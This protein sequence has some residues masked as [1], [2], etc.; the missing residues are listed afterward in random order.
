[1]ETEKL[2]TSCSSP[3]T[4]SKAIE[5][6]G[7]NA[8]IETPAAKHAIRNL[9]SVLKSHGA[10][11]DHVPIYRTLDEFKKSAA[12][13][14][15]LTYFDG[16]KLRSSPAHLFHQE[17]RFGVCHDGQTKLTLT[18]L[19]FVQRASDG[20]SKTKKAKAN[21][22][23]RP[24]SKPASGGAAAAPSRSSRGAVAASA[25]EKSRELRQGAV[26]APRMH[27]LYVGASSVAAEAVRIAFPNVRQTIFD[28]AENMMS[29]MPGEYRKR[30]AFYRSAEEL[31]QHDHIAALPVYY[32]DETPAVLLRKRF[33]EDETI[34]FASDIR[35]NAT[36]ELDIVADMLNQKKWAVALRSHWYMFKFRI[37]YG[38]AEVPRS[39]LIAM[40]NEAQPRK[41]KAV[42]DKSAK[43]GGSAE[44]GGSADRISYLSGD[45]MIQPYSPV[46]SGELR[47]IGKRSTNGVMRNKKYDLNEIE[48]LIF[49]HNYFWRTNA[50]FQGGVSPYDL[51]AERKILSWFDSRTAGAVRRAI[52]NYRSMSGKQNAALCALRH[53][54]NKKLRPGAL[55][56]LVKA[57]CAAQL[58]EKKNKEKRKDKQKPLGSLGLLRRSSRNT[59]SLKRSSRAEPIPH[60]NIYKGPR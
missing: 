32:T 31:N 41:A 11:K 42:T 49:A 60:S 59:Q 4:I 3:Q 58:N 23:D 51:A 53:K 5:L 29:L 6:I 26:E 30:A 47:L 2:N 19:E 45:L 34:L 13:S 12:P 54:T 46:G 28:P 33:L 36:S 44:E 25:R 40:Y 43:A 38:S 37:P 8:D 16:V 10:V 20:A 27:L 56:A 7:A 21:A 39:S 48:D 17:I 57:D 50:V 14:P 35:M 1:M 15:G 52:E 55:G 24:L 9:Q 18:L 22:A